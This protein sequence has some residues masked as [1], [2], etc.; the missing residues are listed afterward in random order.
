[1]NDLLQVDLA[2]AGLRTAARLVT[3]ENAWQIHYH[4]A[5][6]LEAH[7]ARSMSCTPPAMSRR[8]LCLCGNCCCGRRVA[9]SALP[10][11]SSCSAGDPVAAPRPAT[12]NR[13]LSRPWAPCI[14]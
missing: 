2:L 12:P 4:T 6:L 7:A 8:P 10:L 14:F 13:Q 5:L 1:M 11:A 9:W 3:G